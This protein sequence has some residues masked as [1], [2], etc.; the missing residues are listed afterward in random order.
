[1]DR[2]I[3]LVCHDMKKAGKHCPVLKWNLRSEHQGSAISTGTWHLS[4]RSFNPSET[5]FLLHYM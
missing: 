5:Q 1:M 2:A 3:F 4:N